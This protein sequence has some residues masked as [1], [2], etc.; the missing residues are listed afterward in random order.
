MYKTSQND[1]QII[2][3]SSTYPILYRGKYFTTNF[4]GDLQPNKKI[5]TLSFTLIAYND[6][7]HRCLTI[8]YIQL[9]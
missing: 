6:T 1:S 8:H 4:Y 3:L 2:V 7:R 9:Q 5:H